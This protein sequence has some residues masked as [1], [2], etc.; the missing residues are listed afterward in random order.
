MR[1]IENVGN[2]STSDHDVRR[3]ADLW[4]GTDSPGAT[5]ALRYI[6]IKSNVVNIPFPMSIGVRLTLPM[7]GYSVDNH[8]RR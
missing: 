3:F 6:S 2:P 5:N 1:R 8:G 4:K 7:N